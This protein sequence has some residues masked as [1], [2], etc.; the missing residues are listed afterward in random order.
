MIPFCLVD[1]LGKSLVGDSALNSELACAVE[2][3]LSI[4]GHYDGSLEDPTAFAMY[5]V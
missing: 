3:H 4:N 1:G 5:S 2:R